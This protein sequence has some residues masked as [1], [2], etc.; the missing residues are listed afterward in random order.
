ME[1]LNL[2]P[3]SQEPAA[4]PYPEPTESSPHPRTLLLQVSSQRSLFSDSHSKQ[5][6][7]CYF[8][9]H[10][11]FGP[12]GACWVAC[13]L[14]IPVLK[15]SE[16]E[17][18]CRDF[19]CAMNVW[20]AAYV[21]HKA[22]QSWS[23]NWLHTSHVRPKKKKT[24]LVSWTHIQI[25]PAN[26]R[27][28]IQCIH[29]CHPQ[30]LGSNA[31]FLHVPLFLMCSVWLWRL[32]QWETKHASY[33]HSWLSL[34]NFIAWKGKGEVYGIGHGRVWFEWGLNYSEY[35]SSLW[36]VG[37]CWLLHVARGLHRRTFCWHL[38]VETGGSFRHVLL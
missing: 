38:A 33:L 4:G 2:L 5:F 36:Y 16:K 14:Q 32:S 13:L 23:K 37:S 8:L 35:T 18:S 31:L 12:L 10:V 15:Q 6:Q 9:V 11:S 21:F 24:I 20:R 26:L 34:N 3:C 27:F 22:K 30:T 1:P 19:Q 28:R 29:E 25:Y 17:S 7:S